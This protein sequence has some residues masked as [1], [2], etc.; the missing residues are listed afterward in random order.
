MAIKWAYVYNIEKII[1]LKLWFEN[2]ISDYSNN[3]K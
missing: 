3:G 2:E 1:A